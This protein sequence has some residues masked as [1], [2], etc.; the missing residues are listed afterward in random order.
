MF[1]EDD[2]RF[3][4]ELEREAGCLGGRVQLVGFREDVP[5]WMRSA[6]VVVHSSTVPEPF[7][8]VIV[9]AMFAGKP[10][11]ATAAGGPLEIVRDGETGILVPPG[12][13]AALAEGIRGLLEAPTLAQAMG[14]AG[15]HRAQE[16]FSLSVVLEQTRRVV[17]SNLRP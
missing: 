2:R 1:T 7:G 16:K 14:R 4:Q 6:H 15:R 12:D 17:Y 10:V 5:L 13:P 3:A 9:E 11:V 8:R